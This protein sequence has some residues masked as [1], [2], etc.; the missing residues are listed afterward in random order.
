[1]YTKCVMIVQ[2]FEPRGWRFTN[3]YYYYY[4]YYYYIIIIII[5][6]DLLSS[7]SCKTMAIISH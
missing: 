6:I 5:V 3:Y 7:A 1:M 2:R 4:Y